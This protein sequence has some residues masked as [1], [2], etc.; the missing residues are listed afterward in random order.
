MSEQ[1]PG[2][3]IELSPDQI[4]ALPARWSS[5]WTPSDDRAA[6]GDPATGSYLLGV[7]RE[8]HD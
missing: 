3:G 8:P 6:A 5:C 1:L 4:E 2:G 7:F